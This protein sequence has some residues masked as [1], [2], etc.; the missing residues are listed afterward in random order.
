MNRIVEYVFFFGFM[1]VVA[2]LVW[3]LI[4]PFIS[5]LA[6]AAIIVTICYPLYTRII[7]R[8][9]W[10]N[11]SLAAFITTLFVVV[12]ILLPFLLLISTVVSEAAAIYNAAE[13]GGANLGT[14][15]QQLQ[16]AL[17][18]YIPAAE[19]EV[20][21]IIQEVTN[22]L[23]GN[24]GAIFVSTAST[25]FS[26]FIALIASFYLFRDGREFTKQLVKISPLPDDQ[27]EL[28]LQRLG[29]AVRS[30]ATGTVLVALTQGTLTA[31]GLTIFGI[32]Q[33]ILW[34]TI[35]AIGALI[36]GV[37]TA[38]VLIPAVLFLIYSGDYVSAVGLSVWGMV[39]VGTIDNILGPYLMSRGNPL[40]PFIILIAVLGGISVFGPIGFIVGPV[41]VSLFKVLL[42]LYVTHI[43][44]VSEVTTDASPGVQ[45]QHKS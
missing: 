26:F 35:A 5:A 42:E 18:T 33:A 30:V 27:D 40:H 39:A 12:V 7:R 31:I 10:Q 19:L 21:T 22:W 34:G 2:Y 14:T 13:R 23:R 17:D 1:G 4:A 41:I 9:P 11:Q 32:D 43:S 38:I 16:V 29:Q 8:T 28:I 3:T 6:L 45:A 20:A 37:G 15:A 25:V 44:E 36:P 24:L